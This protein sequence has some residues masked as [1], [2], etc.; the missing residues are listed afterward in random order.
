MGKYGRAFVAALVVVAVLVPVGTAGAFI[1]G[2][3]GQ[4]IKISPPPAVDHPGALDNNSV[5][6]AWDEQQGVTLTSALRVDITAPGTYT[7][8]GS[9]VNA[10][11]PVGPNV[12]SHFFDSSVLP[13]P[14]SAGT[15]KDATLVFPTDVIAIVIRPGKIADSTFLGAPGTNYSTS[16]AN[17]DLE[18]DGASDSITL[19]ANRRVVTI[20]AVSRTGADVDQVRILTEHDRPPVANAGGPY[21]APEGGTVVLNGAASDPEN[22]PITISWSFAVSAS[23]GTNCT[24]GATNTLSPTISCNDDAVVQATLSVADPYHP[25]VQSVGVVTFS[26][27]A[28]ALGA[29]TAPVT[30]VPQTSPVNISANFTDVSTHDTHTAS[31]SWG[32]TTSSSATIT[33]G[34]G[35]GSLSGSHLYAARGHYTITV[36]LYDDDGGVDVKTVEVD[37]N[38]APTA[39]AA[40]PYSGNEGSATG[41]IGTAL[42][43]DG[44]P[45]T[46][47]WSFTPISQD[48]GTTCTPANTNSLSASVNCNDD[49]VLDAKLTADDGVNVPAESHTTVT[50]N[51]VA[52]LLGTIST[53]VTPIPVNGTVNVSAPFSD[54][55]AHDT[56]TASI[57]WG[58]MTTTPAS[59]SESNGSGSLSGSHNYATPGIYQITVTV[60]DD[61]GGVAQDTVEILVNAPPTAN[62]GGPYI[63]AEGSQ[64]TLTGTANDVNADTLTYLWTF[65]WTGDPGTNCDTTGTN[66]LS[67][68]LICNDDAVVTAKL[69][70]SD[71]VNLP[72]YSTATVTVANVAPVIGSLQG[73][74]P[75]VPA[76]G[77]YSIAA[78]FSDAG[79]NDTH[80]AT[81]D[82]GDGGPTTSGTVSEV[83]GSGSVSANHSYSS[84]GTFVVTLTV[85]DD[86]GDSDVATT[87]VIVMPPPT[88]SAGG[89]YSGV[90]GTPV[91]LAGT[92]ANHVSVAWTKTIVTA[93][94][95]TSCTFTGTN[96]LTPALTCTDDA[97]VDVTLTATNSLNVTASDTKTVTITNA[98]PVVNTPLLTPNP[99]PAGSP[100]SA[101][102]TFTDLGVNDT[103][104]ATINWGDATVTAGSV[105]ELAGQGTASGSHAYAAPGTYTVVVKVTD[106]DGGVDSASA[107]VVVVASASVSAGGP[108]S[109]SEGSPVQL[110]GTVSGSGGPFGYSWAITPS[111]PAGL[112]CSLTGGT[113]LTPSVTCND[114][115]SVAAT[116]TVTAGAAP[117]IS[118]G[119]TITIANVAP[120]IS[121]ITVPVTPVPVGTSI[122]ASAA[123]SDA[124]SNDTHTASIDWGD[125]SSSPATVAESFGA[126]TASGS[127]AYAA[128]GTYTVKAT[129]TDKDGGSTTATA[130]GYVVVYDPNAGFVT[131]GGWISS[132][133]GAYTPANSADP[134]YVGKANFGL[135]SKYL[136]GSTTPSGNTEF[137]LKSANLNF[138][139][140]GM[141]WL[142]VTNS[143]TNATFVGTG[144]VNNTG[145]YTFLVSVV[146][147]KSTGTTDRIRIRVVNN[148]NNV[149]VYDNQYGAADL[150]PATQAV[151]GGSAVIHT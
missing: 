65:T 19:S 115:A 76:G 101:S 57:K 123:F 92:A 90:E 11:L 4:V 84:D 64:L 151:S 24:T 8:T 43:P 122:L 28:P 134:D 37:V 111:G 14:A 39:D 108:Y 60:T 10:L 91:T 7:T 125:A 38:G 107:Q 3:I 87:Q 21:T 104:T 53:P 78:T 73:S 113:T 55:G 59:V 31:I 118:A 74:Q 120:S 42:D 95:G 34:A 66:T 145:S 96:T 63:G 103:H 131:A 93:A 16:S 149:V 119:T 82:W 1:S 98:A 100:V 72:V 51:N 13:G 69:K 77:S 144:T 75:I 112:S 126:G 20:H 44:D 141:S 142:V 136:P 40:G 62:A 109:G 49:A 129:V 85:T 127:H 33:Q 30:L 17:N 56:H 79:T 68:T 143:G 146:D 124:G 138:H 29:V 61:N 2:T 150:A 9:L 54:V 147:G 26:N 22:D 6:Y 148:A 94:P 89:P 116:L 140:T 121:G 15:V 48:P 47:T 102:A 23:P 81:V 27:V 50:I 25:P 130:T 139:A 86:N 12:D 128:S 135:V 105:S 5:A 70:V 71:G 137:D 99:A 32:D 58:D 88:A 110:T 52:P 35:S 46:T 133:S 106:K 114:N 45:L 67:P 97:I 18:L 36:T 132:P 117:P 83:L 80:T 41:V